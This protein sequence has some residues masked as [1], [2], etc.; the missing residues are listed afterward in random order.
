MWYMVSQSSSSFTYSSAI[1]KLHF[2][3]ACLYVY[4]D[5][6]VYVYK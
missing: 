1:Y 6:N 3:Y 2:I 5:V 4:I